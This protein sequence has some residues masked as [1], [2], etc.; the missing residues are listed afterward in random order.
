VT[1][2]IERTA[3]AELLA[4]EQDQFGFLKGIAIPP[5]DYEDPLDEL[6]RRRAASPDEQA[7][8]ARR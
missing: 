2:H 1:A 6:I 7:A 8:T 3:G 4:I 5:I